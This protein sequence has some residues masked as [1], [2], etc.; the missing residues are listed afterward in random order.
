MLLANRAA[1]EVGLAEDARGVGGV[2][3]LDALVEALKALSLV[4][5]LDTGSAYW[6]SN[7][8]RAKFVMKTLTA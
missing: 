4:L 1:G 7:P 6:V 2:V 5:I 3:E 8:L